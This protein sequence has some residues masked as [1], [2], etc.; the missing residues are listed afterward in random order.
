MYINSFPLYYDIMHDVHCPEGYKTIYY[1]E[2]NGSFKENR[3]F[4][5][6]S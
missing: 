2:I 1:E 4:T 3:H 5:Q 6:F